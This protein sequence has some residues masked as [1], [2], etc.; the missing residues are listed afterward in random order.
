MGW[1]ISLLATQL[2][3]LEQNKKK[4]TMKWRNT[5]RPE[6]A[7]DR[8]QF[9]GVAY[10]IEWGD[11]HRTSTYNTP[12]PATGFWW[13]VVVD[14]TPKLFALFCPWRRPGKLD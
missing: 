8:G 6:S 7:G 2:L 5:A 10:F 13:L 3:L 1:E 9:A 4:T 14:D 12:R 11:L